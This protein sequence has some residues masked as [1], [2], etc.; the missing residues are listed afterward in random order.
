MGLQ[1]LGSI[2]AQRAFRGL[3]AEGLEVTD[4]NSTPTPPKSRVDKV[5]AWAKQHPVW[6]S[7]IAIFCGHLAV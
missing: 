1:T 2:R 4:T 5:K 6:S 7:V 3:I